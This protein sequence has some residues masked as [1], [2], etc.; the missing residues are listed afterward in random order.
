MGLYKKGLYNKP[1]VLN[2]SIIM[3]L[4]NDF[5]RLLFSYSAMGMTSRVHVCLKFK[6]EC[7]E[8]HVII[9]RVNNAKSSLVCS[10]SK[11]VV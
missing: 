4:R 11:P 9:P 7:T 1:K 10:E 8:V 3:Q 6:N 2:K 5:N